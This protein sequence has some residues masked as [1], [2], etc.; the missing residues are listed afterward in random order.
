MIFSY[1]IIDI[2]KDFMQSGI[3]NNLVF[4]ILLYY[5]VPIGLCISFIIVGYVIYKIIKLHKKVKFEALKEISEYIHRGSRTYLRNQLRSLITIIGILFIPVG[6][7][8]IEYLENPYISVIIAALVFMIGSLSSYVASYIGMYSATRTNILVVDLVNEDPNKGFRIAYLSGM[9]TGILNISLLILGIWLIFI[10]SNGDVYL[11]IPY[12]FGASTAAL[13]AQV[14]GGI[15]TKSADIGAD[16]VG[17]FD[18]GINEDDPR[19]AGIIA[20]LVGDNV[21]D[22]A[23][24][25]ADLFESE[26]SDA[27]GGMVLGL[28]IFIFI[29]NPIFIIVNM[30]LI[31]FGLF[32]LYF[33]TLFLKIDFNNTSKSIWRVFN[34]SIIFN[35]VSLVFINI[36][37]F[38]IEGIVLFISSSFGLTSSLITIIFTI[39]YTNIEHKPTKRIAELSKSS[40]SLNIIGGIQ[41]GLDAVFIPILIFVFSLILTF[42]F[43]HKFG[44]ILIE[45]NGLPTFDLLGNPINKNYLLLA[46][47]I[48]GVNMA[49]V[50]S[51]TII[52]TILAFD[53]FGPIT[54]NA[55]GIVELS[56]NGNATN[57]K[58]NLD[59]LDA[60]GNTTKAIA[61]GFALICGGLSSIVIFFSFLLSIPNLSS[62]LS[63]KFI[64]DITLI[65]IIENLDIV[66]PLVILGFCVGCSI[67]VIFSAMILKAV[68]EGA[69]SIISEIKR[70]FDE[71]P[72]LKDGLNGVK[73]D[74][75]K[76]IDISSRNALN[77]MIKPV[78]TV[79]SIVII[80][81][82]LFGPIVVGSLLIGNLAS[83]LIFGFF[84]SI[85]GGSLDNAKKGIESGLFGGK[86]SYAHKSAIIG[87]TVGD[88]L[89]DVAGPSM[90]IIITTINNLA[91]TFL[92][93]FI[94]TGF[95]WPLF[96]V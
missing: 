3:K 15:Y 7:N 78:L 30:M 81:G 9:I 77:H 68:Q 11:M 48:W 54:D 92:P 93:I 41:V 58:Y 63:N 14:G 21:G 89:K 65:N 4:Y 74:Y 53:T 50:S 29:G 72:G 96:N 24:R 95:L 8:G 1:E 59:R 18:L 55:A 64:N 57:L 94:M 71:I 36:L 22:C 60:V 91:L 86:N 17:K 47:G 75:N 19:N 27:I 82:I 6:L 37:F 76:C 25:G 5:F 40:P 44:S 43:G 28:L 26:S 16:L 34:S 61:K 45:L 83:S 73:P 84:M 67:P 13:L 12:D 80:S 70:Q 56:T 51:D 23:G 32:S 88:P 20:D 69:E 33:S 62:Q 42:I 31:L 79:I 90:N 39:Y 2:L 49:S 87:D 46:F 52:S 35:L 10:I 38:G 85:A 66:K